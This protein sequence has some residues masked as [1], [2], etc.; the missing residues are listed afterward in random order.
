VL[1]HGLFL[2]LFAILGLAMGSFLNVCSDRLPIGRSIINPPSACATCNHRLGAKDLVP[3]FSYL[4][5]R[6]RC[7]YCHTPIPSRL[8]AVEL[9]L[10]IVF[11][12]L[13]WHYGLSL[14]LG[15]SLIYA[16]LLT[17]ILVIDIEH[18]LILDKV[19]YP[20]MGL[21]LALSLFYP[22]LGVNAG[23]RVVSSISGGAV[24]LVIMLLPFFLTRGGMGMGDVKMAALLGLIT[25]FPKVFI[26]LFLSI[27]AGGLVAVAL[28]SL[29]LKKRRQP[30][31][32]GP[33]LAMGTMAVIVW[34]GEI[35]HWY[36]RI[37]A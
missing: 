13:Y 9:A 8:P 29:G 28:L 37:I 19:V 26:A 18:Q 17:L 22:A 1:P 15:F 10:G 14:E 35:Q 2:A 25:G 31:P 3:L 32:F 20:G 16:C 4:W 7:R 33:F 21:A 27:M 36:Q 23:S 24:G 30:I 6:G 5:L 11:P 12:L 34:G